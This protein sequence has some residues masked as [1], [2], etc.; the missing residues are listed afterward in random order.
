MVIDAM[1]YLRLATCSLALI[2][3][4]CGGNVAHGIAA[5]GRQKN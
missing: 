2:L 3:A 5:A 4:G 1:A